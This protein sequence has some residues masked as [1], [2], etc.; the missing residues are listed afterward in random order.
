MVTFDDL[1]DDIYNSA[2]QLDSSWKYS[3]FKTFKRP[4]KKKHHHLGQRL[5]RRIKK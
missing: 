1:L 3:T 2:E 5:L 4:P